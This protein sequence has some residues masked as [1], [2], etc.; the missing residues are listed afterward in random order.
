MLANLVSVGELNVNVITFVI[1]GLPCVVN[2]PLGLTIF[3]IKVS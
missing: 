2:D 1:T 3:K